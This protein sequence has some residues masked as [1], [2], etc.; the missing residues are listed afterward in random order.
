MVKKK[1]YH[2]GDLRRVLIET[3]LGVIRDEGIRGITLRKIARLA[4]VSHAAP[5][6]HF[7]DLSGLL[8]AVAEK[9]FDDLFLAL[10]VA[11]DAADTDDPLV[12]FK[13]AG[14]AYVAFAAAEPASIKAM[15]HPLLA[16]RRSYP[17]LEVAS[18]RPFDLLLSSVADCQQAGMLKAMDSRAAALFAWCTVHGLSALITDGHLK[19]K[20]FDDNPELLADNLTG[21]IFSGLRV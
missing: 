3:A 10:T 1:S 2:H 7:K 11:I 19:G 9:G 14:M 20:G 18:R 16:D 15:F 8:A 12:R 5:A 17:S 6:H 21:L 13:A 4:G